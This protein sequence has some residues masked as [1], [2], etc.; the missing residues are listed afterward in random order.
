MTPMTSTVTWTGGAGTTNWTD[1]ANWSTDALPGAGADVVINV[2]TATTI[3]IAYANVSIDSLTTNAQISVGL[4]ASLSAAT[5]NASANVLLE[6]GTIANT[7]I[8][9]SPGSALVGSAYP[10][11]TL[12]GVTASGLLDMSNA[13]IDIADGLTLNNATMLL[14]DTNGT[15]FGTLWF[16]NT[17]TLGGTGTIILGNDAARRSNCN[18]RFRFGQ[19][20]ID[21]DDRS[22]H[23]H[24]RQLGHV[25]R[26]QHRHVHQ[27]GHLY[28][29]G[30]IAA[31]AL[32][33]PETSATTPAT[34]AARRR[35][36]DGH[37]R[38]RSR[39]S[40]ASR[41]ISRC[42]MASGSATR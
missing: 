19:S 14:G 31:D 32:S 21:G 17:E 3:Q 27:C 39:R 12:D 26:L 15:T 40:C 33:H 41:F 35:P 25:S 6:G 37:R 8:N 2:A 13:G 28:H 10:G 38:Q 34:A 9:M 4:A 20:V 23:H 18:Q 16:T 29:Q 42:A 7:T 22:R 30:T 11:G 5:L 24:S 36:R 1:A